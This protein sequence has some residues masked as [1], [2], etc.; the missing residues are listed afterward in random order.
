[1][2]LGVKEK[3]IDI[4]LGIMNLLLPP[5]QKKT[6]NKKQKKT[7]KQNKNKNKNKKSIKKKQQ[8]NN[9]QKTNIWYNKFGVKLTVLDRIQIWF[10][11]HQVSSRLYYRYRPSFHR[12]G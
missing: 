8:K 6:K 3:E 1:M 10:I 12:L 11:N 7:K 5:T 9:N 2:I 4:R